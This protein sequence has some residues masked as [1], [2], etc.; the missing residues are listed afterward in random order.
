MRLE[1]P[2]SQISCRRHN[3]RV[4]RATRGRYGV[5][6]RADIRKVDNFCATRRAARH[7]GTGISRGVSG[8]D[9]TLPEMLP[10]AVLTSQLSATAALELAAEVFG[11]CVEV[12][13]D[14]PAILEAGALVM[15]T[16]VPL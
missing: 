15:S 13:Q 16:P 14:G 8:S 6:T 3:V 4:H 5:P 7:H 11:R 10:E 12:A 2:T 9:A 1:F